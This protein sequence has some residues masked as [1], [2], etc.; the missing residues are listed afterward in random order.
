MK[1]RLI[2]LTDDEA[3]KQLIA[4]PSEPAKELGFHTIPSA[5]SA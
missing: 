3:I 4:T 2:Q 1:D 5:H